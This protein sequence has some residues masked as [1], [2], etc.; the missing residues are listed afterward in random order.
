[1]VTDP[2][3]YIDGVREGNRLV[4]AKAIT[5]IESSLPAHQEAART[6]VD[7]LLPRTGEAVRLGLTGVPGVGKSTFIESFGMG[8]LEKGHKVAVLAIDPSSSRSGGSV[9][10]DK[11]RMEKLSVQADAFIRPSPSGRTLGGVA[12]KT[13]E[14]LLLCEAAG[15]DVVIV[16]TVGV[17]QSETAVASMTD[18][19][20]VLM[21][22]GAGD[23]LQG[24]K[25][26]VLEMADAIAINKADADNIEKA[27]KARKQY[28]MALHL[29]LPA[30]PFWTPPVL[31][32]SAKEKTGLTDIWETVIRH[33]D[34]LVQKG[35]L[36]QKRRRQALEWMWTLL[37]EGLKERFHGHPEVKAQLPRVAHEVEKEIIT[38][39]KGATR[40]LSLLDN[41]TSG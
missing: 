34:L 21:L 30:S 20:L 38:P 6:I 9:M 1:M 18:F 23:E 7:A 15:F 19:F 32:C 37:E 29:V 35:E 25:K 5:L 28:E 16:E 12:R 14:S 13:R 31:T 41:P 2:Q 36:K 10:A 26:G 8:L 24:I 4:L 11:T 3:Y 40:L 22:A 33:R 27:E 17:G 39:T